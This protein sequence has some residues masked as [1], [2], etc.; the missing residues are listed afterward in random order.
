[1][2]VTYGGDKFV[3]YNADA[4]GAPPQ[5]TIINMAFQELEIL[6]RANVEDGY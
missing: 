4:E 2:D 5:R 3:T 6:D 1:M